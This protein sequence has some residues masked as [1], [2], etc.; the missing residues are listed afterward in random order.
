[1]SRWF[2]VYDDLVD[3]PKVQRLSAEL[4]RARFL[5]A[6]KGEQNEF[7]DFVRRPKTFRLP[8]NEWAEIRS[9]IFERDDYTCRYCGERG[10]KLECD[11]VIPHSRGGPDTDDNLVTACFK[12]N[13]SK[14]DKTPEEWV[15]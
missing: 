12:C 4:F 7:A 9:R 2:R 1:M 11:H 3:D 5:A 8:A 14:K 10:G 15:Q 6:A 13:R